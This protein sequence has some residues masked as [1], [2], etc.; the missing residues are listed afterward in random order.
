M[1]AK[2]KYRGVEGSTLDAAIVMH[3]VGEPSLN[4]KGQPRY[5]SAYANPR[6]RRRLARRV[7]LARQA[8]DKVLAFS[9]AVTSEEKFAAQAEKRLR[10]TV[11]FISWFLIFQFLAPIVFRWIWEWATTADADTYRARLR[12]RAA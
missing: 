12:S 2:L 8:C 11:G 4:V 6:K 10:S 1:P 5:E 3:L 7:K 9:P